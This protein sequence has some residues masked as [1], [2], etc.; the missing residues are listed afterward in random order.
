MIPKAWFRVI[1]SS[2]FLTACSGG[3]G[4]GPST[5]A[6]N[7]APTVSAGADQTAFEGQ[8]VVLSGNVSDPNETPTVLWTQTSG[9][10]VTLQ[11]AET[12]T[13]SFIAPRVAGRDVL[14]FR[15]TANDGVNAAVSDDVNITV[16]DDGIRTTPINPPNTSYI[17]PEI[18][19]LKPEIVFQ[20]N[21]EGFVQAY[22]P[23]T[24]LFAEGSVRRMFDDVAT[25]TDTKNGP[26]YGLD[27][28]GVAI[29]YNK[30]ASDG[31]LQFFRARENTNGTFTVDQVTPN[32]SE[33]INQLPSQN[34]DA[35]T[36][37]LVY[38]REDTAAPFGGGFI[39]YADANDPST[40]IDLTP[41]RAGFSGFRWVRGTS[42]F[43]T[44]LSTGADEGQVLMVNAETGVQ[45]VIT[46][47][48]GVKFDP[49]G[50]FPPEFGSAMAF[51][52]ITGAGGDISIYRDTGGPFFELYSVQ[53]PASSSLPFAQSPEPFVAEDGTSYISLTLADVP[54]SIFT[55]ATEAD[56]WVYGIEDGADRFTLRCS[57]DEPM[58]IRHEAEMV[59]G[60]NEALLYF[61]RIDPVGF[62][63]LILCETGLAP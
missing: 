48:P 18:H 53:P 38:A 58:V 50:W 55:D 62:F 32:G 28:Q 3:G 51:S 7:T 22:D 24:G 44:T 23:V 45:T 19:P 46:N 29:Y 47:D 60:A 1:I 49:F 57:D 30:E 61:N 15:L 52:A 37:W 41:V 31:T 16:E 33:R 54:D 34:A 56:I 11:N 25:L 8:N 17:D 43:L 6:V 26:E 21:G 35:S 39:A 2:A 42:I 59:S 27:D 36:T 12:S 20:F 13:A 10:A 9:P 40:E 63:E 5:P 14:T 4:S